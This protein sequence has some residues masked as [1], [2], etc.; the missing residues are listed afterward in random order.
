MDM[1]KYFLGLDMGTNS[2]GWAVT[3]TQYH[4]LRA[5]GKDLWGARLFDEAETAAA[6][7]SYRT[8][9][10]RLARQKLRNGYLRLLFSDAINRIDPGFF[11]RLDESNLYEEDKT[12]HQ[13]YAL[14][15][16]RKDNRPFTDKEFYAQYP[17]IFHLI[18]DL[19]HSPEPKD[20]RLVY[21]AVLNIFNHRGHFLNDSLKSTGAGQF[22]ELFQTLQEQDGLFQ[23]VED[24][25]VFQ[26][27]LTDRKL[28]N[29]QKREHLLKIFSSEIKRNS[30]EDERV[31]LL[32]GLKGKLAKAFPG[33]ELDE[34][35]E[36]LSLSFRDGDYDE[37]MEEILGALDNDILDELDALK[38]IHDWAMISNLMAG[39][40]YISEARVALY[41]KHHQDLQLLKKAYRTWC[42]KEYDS[43]F[44]TM[45]DNNYSAYAGS[46]NAKDCKI[47]RGAKCSQEDF[48]KR[49]KKDLK[50]EGKETEK[51]KKYIWEEIQRET[52]LPKQITPSN[53]VIPYQLHLAELHAI[54]ENAERYLPFLKESDSTG[55]TVAQKIE[56]LFSFRIPYFV[57]PL[58]KDPEGRNK[59]WVVR[60]EPGRVLPWNFESKVDLKESAVQFIQE[61]VGHCTYLTDEKVLPNESLL[62]EK[63]R[64]LNELNN[65]KVNGN[66]ISVQLKQNLYKDLFSKGKKVTQKQVRSYLRLNG[67]VEKDDDIELTGIDGDFKN[68]LSSHA[69]F[70]ALLGTSD[71]TFAQ[72]KMAEEIIGWAT[73][74]GDSQK[75]LRE[76]IQD[77]YGDI[78]SKAQ[79]KRL[80]GYKFRDWGRLSREFLELPGVDK[81]TGEQ[82]PLIQKMWES[83]CNLMQ[84]LSDQFTYRETVE[85]K[86]ARNEK[87]LTEIQ[88]EDLADLYVS[89]PVRRMIWQTILI[90]KELTKVLGAAPSRIFV[91]MARDANA[92]KERTVSRKARLVDLYKAMKGEGKEF[93]AE[94]NKKSEVDFR[95][96]RLYLYYCQM[97]RC[98]YT[99]EPIDL[100]DLFNDNLYDIDHIYPRHF[101]KD[102]SL[103]NNLVLVRKEKNAHKTDIFPIEENIRDRQYGFWKMLLERRLITEE[104]FL[105]LTRNTPFT[106]EELAGFI[107]RQIVETRQG[108]KAIA[109][110]LTQS[111]P[112]SEI[113][114]VKAG[115][116]SQFRQ[117]FG[118][119]K[120][121]AVND[122]HHAHDAYLNIVVG[123]TYHV[124]F[125]RSPMNFIQAYRKDPARN[126]YHMYRLFDYTVARNGEVA[127][128]KEKTIK[129]VKAVLEKPSVLITRKPF[130]AHGGFSDATILSASD[131]RNA[132][133]KGYLPV[134]T[135]DEKIKDSCKYGGKTKITGS[136]FFLVESTQKGK[137]VRTLEAMPLYLV[138]QMTDDKAMLGYCRDTLK[139]ADPRI[140]LKKI[141]M[142]SLL[143]INGALVYLTGR[144]GD[145]VTTANAV[146]LILDPMLY[147]YVKKLSDVAAMEVDEEYLENRKISK[148]ENLELYDALIHKYETGILGKRINN[149]VGKLK[150]KRDVFQETAII[151]QIHVL[152]EILKLSTV[153][154]NGVDLKLIDGAGKSGKAAI[155]KNISNLES[156]YLIT[157][158]VTG[159]YTKSID[160]L[161]V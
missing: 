102:D 97:G 91:E 137:R 121:R 39:K 50:L 27:I 129:T 79:L 73:A 108:T 52:F 119:V 31:K 10:R 134:K 104:K 115:N 67:Y 136:Y 45:E 61:L 19:I 100:H 53:G 28:T 81:T 85:K 62:Y 8:A 69:R 99:G 76:K 103:D 64:V 87:T 84:L 42:P 89:N 36:K 107:Q 74:F 94:I 109:N 30:P 111:F 135:S 2:V 90:L 101:L 11:Q 43:M 154:N 161:R 98:M 118:L 160:L 144:T 158:S 146:Q 37:K 130:E 141:K 40:K 148:E 156:A 149:V 32:C 86:V 63:F 114:Y 128:E 29:G 57:G 153:D 25:R 78:L 56:E 138:D 151:D 147:Q 46:V 5:K 150:E 71:F 142:Y 23:Q 59:A 35:H 60:K 68:T 155:N 112:D 139:L 152:M 157:Q 96:K 58:Y 77:K 38:N 14:F 4:L 54:L 132:Q 47:R 122:F 159:L 48:Y 75:F 49:I 106:D 117:N 1:D 93:L 116:V 83:N 34:A 92:R 80:F 126:P 140:C 72:K 26:E 124:K 88:Y 143:K 66:P 16:D 15:N 125:T 22:D 7:R 131:V 120:A 65:L 41:E 3:D 133:G 21:L 44:R 18:T 70:A 6:R 24:T 95:R 33:L 123:N 13:P 113:V 12:I 105:R 82:L 51:D 145:R 127:W 17:T 20:V 9:R 55:L 110:L